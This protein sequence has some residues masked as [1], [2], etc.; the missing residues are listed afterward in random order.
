MIHNE[1]NKQCHTNYEVEVELTAEEAN[2]SEFDNDEEITTE[3]EL[4]NSENSEEMKEEEREDEQSSSD[5]DEFDD[6][7]ISENTN[8]DEDVVDSQSSDDEEYEEDE[9]YFSSPASDDFDEDSTS[10]A[11]DEDEDIADSKY[12][13]EKEDDEEFS[14][15]ASDGFDDDFIPEQEEDDPNNSLLKSEE[16]LAIIDAMPDVP[17]INDEPAINEGEP[18]IKIDTLK[19]LNGIAPLFVFAKTQKENSKNTELEKIF[20]SPKE[21]FLQFYHT[22]AEVDFVSNIPLENKLTHKL[23]DEA[24]YVEFDNFLKLFK[25]EF[26]FL[27]FQRIGKELHLI[28]ND[29]IKFPIKDYI[30]NRENGKEIL[31]MVNKK[32]NEIEFVDVNFRNFYFL[33]DT[34][35]ILQIL[36]SYKKGVIVVKDKKAYHI[37]LA[38][39]VDLNFYMTDIDLPDMSF[40]MDSVS[41]LKSFVNCIKTKYKG[42]PVNLKMGYSE[43]GYLTF[44]TEEFLLM[45]KKINKLPISIEDDD[46]SSFSR[47]NLTTIRSKITDM[48]MRI[49][50]LFINRGINGFKYIVEGDTA[51]IV[52]NESTKE[53]GF[54]PMKNYLFKFAQQ[55][56]LKLAPIVITPKSFYDF[57]ERSEKL[58]NLNE[59]NGVYF[60][61]KGHVVISCINKSK[62]SGYE[63][64][65]D[66][67]V[68]K[69]FLRAQNIL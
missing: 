27:G 8:E 65:D 41:M 32:R 40:N 29:E 16:E 47:E 60:D 53:E 4:I 3:I 25:F 9:E 12:V 18:F 11:T 54:I 28:V 14:S 23:L 39:A 50:Y 24:F 64:L 26:K 42:K 17:T 6:D 37:T 34:L 19:L 55:E 61:H 49:Y 57:L 56:G 31:E 66:S 21:N 58:A 44:I 51:Q 45:F 63:A 13:D 5:S 35:S 2:E 20:I 67:F 38:G 7:S 69:V 10:E 33:I 43:E 59:H 30:T 48:L 15:S 68:A 62:R 36:A 1:E 22:S 46:F 52:D